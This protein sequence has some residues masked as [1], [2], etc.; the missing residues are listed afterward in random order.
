[1]RKELPA[2]L[3]VSFNRFLNDIIGKAA[4]NAPEPFRTLIV[5]LAEDC[6]DNHWHGPNHDIASGA[7]AQEG[8]ACDFVYRASQAAD[9]G[10][11]PACADELGHNP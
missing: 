1:M 7:F 2:R 9:T 5:S 6:R 8:G 3:A 10:D 11:W 4:A